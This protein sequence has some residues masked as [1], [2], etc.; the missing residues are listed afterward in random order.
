MFERAQDK[1]YVVG[2]ETANAG[3]AVVTRCRCCGA[4]ATGL[5][6]RGVTC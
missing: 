2:I 1:R 4:N 3:V 5:V 6:D